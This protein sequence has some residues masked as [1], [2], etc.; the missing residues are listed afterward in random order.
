MTQNAQYPSIKSNVGDNADEI[1]LLNVL[2]SVF[3]TRKIWLL[4]V[5]IASL[6]FGAIKAIE[7]LRM[8]PE[9]A[10]SKPI[11][12]T[13]PNAQKLIFPSGAKF[14]YSD[15][16][17]PSVVQAAY[18]RNNLGKYDL[19]VA[20][21]QG[22]LSA[23]PY[24]PTYP[25]IIE[26]YNKLLGDKR[27]TPDRIAELQE[28]L[29]IELEQAT[30]GEALISLR[31][32]DKDL[33]S[34]VI[35]KV[36]DDVPAIWA[37]RTIKEKGVLNVNAQLATANS[38]NV[39]LI[40]N[41]EPLIAGDLL[42]QK[43]KLLKKNI[44][45]LTEFEGSQSITDPQTGMRL[46]DLNYA[47]DDLNQYVIGN[48]FAPVRLLGLS[49]S[50]KTSAFYFEDKINKLKVKLASAEKQAAAIK[51][52]NSPYLQYERTGTTT[53][54]DSNAAQNVT[55]QLSID[56]LDKLVSLS[57]EMDRETYKQKINNDWINL[58][59]EISETEGSISEA[60]RIYT[61]LQKAASQSG[62][63]DEAKQ[64]LD[65]VKNTLPSLL[66]TLKNYFAVS[67]R[68]YYQLSAESV[69][70][71]D[72]LYIP[73]IDGVITQKTLFD[74]KTTFL[75]WLALMFLTTVIVVPTCMIRNALKEKPTI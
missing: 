38:L 14:S 64:Y 19:S 48:L 13:F 68:I 45:A 62:A 73:I 23:T 32:K 8:A 52:S 37:E 54:S 31:L 10:Y 71:R 70:I 33:P 28:A 50:P 60:Q 66:E 6:V 9:A 29:K 65:E 47:V 69:G 15:I 27:I 36:L 43:I 12:L 72:Q 63:S 26:R 53:R 5:I 7:C 3:K 35:N 4:S 59:R 30:G 55:P 17:A 61:A 18:E 44:N 41:E 20:D 21:L 25:F 22:G 42:D 58:T 74:I 34:E 39:E 51:D 40:K 1:D 16:V 46:M 57:S 75:T 24:S 67:E 49:S 56:M 2:S 11:R